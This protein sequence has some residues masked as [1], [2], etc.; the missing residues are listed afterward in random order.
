MEVANSCSHEEF[1]MTE[2]S[3]FINEGLQDVFNNEL[4]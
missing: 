2:I 4:L 1:T 3:R